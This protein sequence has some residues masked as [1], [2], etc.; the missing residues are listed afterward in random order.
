MKQITI[1]TVDLSV[2]RACQ[3]KDRPDWWAVFSA[4][5]DG[6]VYPFV[7]R[8]FT[9][10]QNRVYLRGEFPKLSEVADLYLAHRPSGGRFFIDR[11]GA[12]FHETVRGPYDKF[13]NFILVD[14]VIYVP[15]SA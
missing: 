11:Q 2:F 6:D 8:G 9:Q 3:I 5:P 15:P 4:E 13:V 1:S 7:T 10:R 14:S 12:Y